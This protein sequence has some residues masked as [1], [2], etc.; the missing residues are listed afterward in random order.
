MSEALPFALR[1]ATEDDTPFIVETWAKSYRGTARD[2]GSRIFGDWKMFARAMVKACAVLV[3]CLEDDPT[4]IVGFAV[5]RGNLVAYVYVRDRF[6]QMGV[7]RALLAPYALRK[8]VV[9]CSVP[10]AR[11]FLP[12]GWR[13]EWLSAFRALTEAHQKSGQGETK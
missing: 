4:S 12:E 2:S 3:C 11:R 1:P 8:D 6:R 5:T 13:Y 9:T 10:M 7:A